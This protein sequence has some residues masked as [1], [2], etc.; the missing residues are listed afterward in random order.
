MKQRVIT[1]LVGIPLVLSAIFCAKP[2]PA[3]LLL[4]LVAGLALVELN[5]LFPAE[6][7][8]AARIGMAAAAFFATVA[9]TLYDAL[10]G[11]SGLAFSIGIISSFALAK[12]KPSFLYGFSTLWVL[13]PLGALFRLWEAGLGSPSGWWNW[14]SL[15][16]LLLFPVWAGDSAGIFVGRCCGKHLLAPAISPKKTWEGAIANVCGCLLLAYIVGWFLQVTVLTS[17][18]CGAACAVFGQLG[19]LFES[20][21]KRSAEVKDS[22][23]LLPGH[24]GILDRIDSILFAAPLVYMILGFWR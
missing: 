18:I 23:T 12:K 22:G 3:A 20:Y 11:L 14:Q 16:L 21:L 10:W 5:H 17:L 1:A 7:S 8:K 2:W 19:D 24:G 13:V 6:G 15:T 9:M 4:S